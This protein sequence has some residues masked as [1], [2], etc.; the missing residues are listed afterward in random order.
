VKC[1]KTNLICKD[2]KT[3][4]TT[5]RV[6]FIIS[7][8]RINK[9][10]IKMN[11]EIIQLKLELKKRNTD[12]M[13]RKE[14]KPNFLRIENVKNAIDN[15]FSNVIGKVSKQNIILIEV[16]NSLKILNKIFL[17]ARLKIVL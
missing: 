11:N 15:V 14:N 6:P 3:Y 16:F 5:Y 12:Y 13:E 4:E 7:L 9:N 2:N 1:K 17:S 10:F 8:Q